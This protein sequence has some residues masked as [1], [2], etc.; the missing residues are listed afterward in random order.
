MLH[1][2]KSD[3]ACVSR[4]QCIGA[5]ST[6]E[7]HCDLFDHEAWH[8]TEAFQMWEQSKETNQLIVNHHHHHHHHPL[9]GTKEQLH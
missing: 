3:C 8:K 2:P 1:L 6:S 4:H 5:V 9:L 7:G